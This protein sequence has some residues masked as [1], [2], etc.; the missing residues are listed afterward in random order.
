VGVD[1]ITTPSLAPGQIADFY[2]QVE[3]DRPPG[4]SHT[5]TDGYFSVVGNAA[6]VR[7]YWFE[8]TATNAPSA[9]TIS[10]HRQLFVEKI[11]SQNRNSVA[12]VLEL[13]DPSLPFVVGQIRTFIL[14]SDTA[15]GY[16]QQETAIDFPTDLL[17][18]QS[19]L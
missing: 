6:T 5:D 14:Y 9:N 19:V 4:N 2:F 3:I 10:L 17:Q 8:A 16:D 7:K 11:L 1:N 15:T 12:P 13:D 18:V